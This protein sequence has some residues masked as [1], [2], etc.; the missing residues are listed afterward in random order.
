MDER[1]LNHLVE[2]PANQVFQKLRQR[3][4][5]TLDDREKLELYIGTMLYRV[6][7]RR[8]SAENLYPGVLDDTL[9]EFANEINRL[10][11]V[12]SID[13]VIAA[14]RLSEIESI[15]EQYGSHPP[16]EI[17]D[18]IR[19]PWPS[20]R[21]MSAIRPMTWWI[22]PAPP[23]HFFLI[24]DNP[25]HFF[26][27][28]GIASK[29][30]E[31]MFPLASDLALIANWQGAQRATVYATIR[32]AW[33]REINRRVASEAVHAVFFRAQEHW[34]TELATKARTHL[35]LINWGR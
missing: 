35:S 20:E 15:R 12:G 34:V 6:P 28:L 5:L 4:R 21:I 30:S 14:K 13:P 33:A 7:S 23:G 25:A 27:S 18:H 10:V 31:L 26:R 16:P 19:N 22:V 2:A 29:S 1:E 11:E 32:T 24:S 3:G 9:N 8:L 17:I